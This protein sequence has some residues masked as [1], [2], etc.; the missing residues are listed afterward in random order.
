MC[1]IVGIVS[2][3][4]VTER[5]VGCLEDLEYR[6]YDGAGIA[7][8]T[9]SLDLTRRRARG[10]LI[11]LKNEIV[12]N[13]ISGNIGIGHTRWATHGK[14]SVINAHPH[15]SDKVA[16]VHNGIIE[17]F[18]YLR[19][20]LINKGHV[21]NTDTDTE[22]IVHLITDYINSGLCPK[23]ASRE[24]I[25]ELEGAF[26][27]AIIFEG[28]E[29]LM[30]GTRQ[31]SPLVLG[32]GTGEM[33]LGSDA[34][35][36]SSLTNKLVY[37]E[38]GD[39]VEITNNSSKIFDYKAVEVVREI[40][41]I[42]KQLSTKDKGAFNHYMIK[43]IYD[44]PAVVGQTLRSLI[45]S[46][47]GCVELGNLPFNL[48]EV[49]RVTIVACG[50]S[51]Y[52]AMVA[53]YWFEK[54][55]RVTVDVD[56]ASEFRYRE[57]VMTPGGLSIFISQ[58]GETAD[59]LAAL[60]Y[61]KN[62][63]QSIL[64]IINTVQSSMERE[65]DFVLHTHAGPEIGVASTKSF[66]CQLAVLAC[67]VISYARLCG[68]I[69]DIKEESLCNALLEAPGAMVNILSHD[70]KIKKMALKIAEARDVIYLGRGLEYPIA[71]EGALK[72]KEIS[73]IHAEGYAAGEMK[74]GPIA[75]V[76]HKVPIIVIAPT[77]KLYEKTVS[78]MHEVIA[79]NGQVYFFTDQKGLDKDG[80][81]AIETI[82]L[83][84]M[85]EF[86]TPILYALPVQLLSYHVAVAKGTDV[87]QPR[88]LAKSVTVE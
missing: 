64:S 73:Y 22:T 49:T 17:N 23:A 14:P 88:N 7:T 48:T 45:N 33:F 42:D 12:T 30:I 54:I 63:G 13:P 51:F 58:S 80:E 59:T 39:R 24:A 20:K 50:T 62:H 26:A 78:N 65:S 67:V 27:L 29:N 86:V 43:E 34:I 60:K 5:I 79:R 87:D 72:L 32:Y 2:N 68:K 47:K 69:D 70:D 61:A 11:N 83:P 57:P 38:E 52:A 81:S 19:H 66:T 84:D 74:H 56:I 44:Q 40:I 35:S 6:G 75:L 3:R 25:N 10:K 41:T 1:G 15:L 21:F 46:V 28:E 85:D 71:M 31:G 53:K 37:L 9:T 77:N 8:I 18:Q 55:A 4:D 16:V 82:A 36:I 76:D